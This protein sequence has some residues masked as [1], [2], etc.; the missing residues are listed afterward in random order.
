LR[1]PKDNHECA[2]I[3][4]Y[5]MLY[6]ISIIENNQKNSFNKITITDIPFHLKLQQ[7]FLEDIIIAELKVNI[8]IT[9]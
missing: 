8:S 4:I 2:E 7:Q 3:S 1:D 5:S 6:F 9:Y